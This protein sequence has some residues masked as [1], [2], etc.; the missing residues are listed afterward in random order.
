[1]HSFSSSSLSSPDQTL[2]YVYPP[3]RK[4]QTSLHEID[5][6][7]WPGRPHRSSRDVCESYMHMHRVTYGRHITIYC[8]LYPCSCRSTASYLPDFQVQVTS[9]HPNLSTPEDTRT[10]SR[11]L[12]IEAINYA[13]GSIQKNQAN[14]AA[15]PKGN[16]LEHNDAYPPV[17][18]FDL[19]PICQIEEALS[20][21]LRCHRSHASQQ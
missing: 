12:P 4:Y 9:P 21:T 8:Y 10:S 2:F 19:P 15:N 18:E 3:L 11:P 13:K 7:T 1:M 17:R 6:L 5:A 16:R 20:R 14:S